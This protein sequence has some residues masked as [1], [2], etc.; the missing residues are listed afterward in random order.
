MVGVGL[1]R[2]PPESCSGQRGIWGGGTGRDTTRHLGTPRFSGVSFS[3]LQSF[4]VSG[5]VRSGKYP[6]SGSRPFV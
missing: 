4:P 1:L 2:E 6:R 3:P 5:Q